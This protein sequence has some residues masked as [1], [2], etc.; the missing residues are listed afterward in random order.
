MKRFICILLLATGCAQ[1]QTIWRCGPDGENYSQT[2]CA[3]GHAL[4]T[5]TQRPASDL[6]QAKDL[7]RSDKALAAQLRKERL[8][9]E[10]TAGAPAVG[11]GAS[12]L[13]SPQAPA[14]APPSKARAKTKPA[15]LQQV[16]PA[17]AAAGSAPAT[18]PSSRRT[19]G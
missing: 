3:E 17:P 11:I 16:S 1:A 4:T 6:A 19:K 10:K 18:G 12:R 13:K 14:S 8:V 9:R 2:P 15:T 5:S 7:A